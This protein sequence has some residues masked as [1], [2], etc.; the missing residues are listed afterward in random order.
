[1]SYKFVHHY[2]AE[3]DLWNVESDV[4]PSVVMWGDHGEVRCCGMS[5]V[6]KGVDGWNPSGEVVCQVR[7]C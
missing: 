4:L 7:I 6:W 2:D 3:F 1:V 5:K